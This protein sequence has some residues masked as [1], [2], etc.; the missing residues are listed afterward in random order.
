MGTSSRQSSPTGGDWSRAKRQL[1]NWTKDGGQNSELARAALG[2]F[3]TALGGAAAAAGGAVGGVR[4]AG[5]LG[6]FLSDVERDGLDAALDRRGLADL[7][8][9]EPLAVIDELAG[10]L[11]GA[12]DSPEEAVAR[13]ALIAVL[14]EIFEEAQTFEEMEAI[15]IDEDRLREFVA[16][17]LAEYIFRRVLHELGDRIR[18]NADPADAAKLEARLHD[19]IQ[20]LV[21][22]DLST[23]DPLDF[24][25]TGGEGQARMRELLAE[26]LRM[27]GTD[28]A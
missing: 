7:V 5:G 24:D 27:L 1:T 25:W 21:N 14:A 18:D 26:A 23:I 22:L 28:E 19:D 10:R 17:Y 11:S 16:L 20:A 3:V 13:D 9:G 8:G 6:E 4:T 2:T 15:A 12:G